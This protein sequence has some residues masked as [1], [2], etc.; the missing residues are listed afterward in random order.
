M[1]KCHE[2]VLVGR[3][4]GAWHAVSQIKLAGQDDSTG[5]DCMDEATGR[6]DVQLDRQAQESD[7]T[8]MILCVRAV[9]CDVI[10]STNKLT[11][12]ESAVCGSVRLQQLS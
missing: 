11:A 5:R 10:Q 6:E 2:K 9:Q 12:W 7:R 4:H 3:S 1:L 8:N